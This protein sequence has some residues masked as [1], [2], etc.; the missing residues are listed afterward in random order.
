[1]DDPLKI[2]EIILQA[3]VY[4][5]VPVAAEAMRIADRAVKTYKEP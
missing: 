4:S 3:G 2:I 1:M 5:G